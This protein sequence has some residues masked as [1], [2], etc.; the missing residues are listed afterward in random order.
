MRLTK[1]K[2]GVL[3][4]IVV[5]IGAML[6][7]SVASVSHVD[8]SPGGC[9][10]CFVAHTVA[11]ETPAAHLIFGPEVVGRTTVPAP[12]PVYQARAVQTSLSRGPPSFV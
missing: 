7:A 11:F 1:L 4:V 9:N 3:L 5:A 12:E 8:S 2:T 6:G 10:L